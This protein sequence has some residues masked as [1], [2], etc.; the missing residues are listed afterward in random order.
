MPLFLKLIFRSCPGF[1]G[2]CQ[3]VATWNVDIAFSEKGV[4]ADDTK[5]NEATLE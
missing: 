1:Y 4:F 3:S 5:L 2:V